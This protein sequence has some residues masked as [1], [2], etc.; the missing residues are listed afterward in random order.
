MLTAS[1][2][3]VWTTTV[4]DGPHALSDKIE[5]LAMA[6]ADL[7][8]VVSRHIHEAPGHSVIFLTPLLGEKQL[9]AAERFDF[10]KSGHLHSVRVVGPDEPGLSYRITSAL[11]G[12]G[13]PLRGISAARIDTQFAMYL[14][15]DSEADADR[16][17]A[18]L[19][20]IV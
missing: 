4:K 12:L 14:S 3:D 2:V 15:F 6:G 16:A 7:E 11:A 10:K 13:I 9:K 1:K 18:C 19:N 17:A 20:H 8:F 5:Q